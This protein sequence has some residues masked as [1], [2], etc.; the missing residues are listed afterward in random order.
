MLQPIKEILRVR[1]D[2]SK[3]QCMLFCPWNRVPPDTPNLESQSQVCLCAAH[4]WPVNTSYAK[5]GGTKPFTSTPQLA[6]ARS[7]APETRA[8]Q[9]FVKKYTSHV[10]LFLWFTLMQGDYLELTLI[11]VQKLA[12]IRSSFLFWGRNETTITRGESLFRKKKCV[13]L[14]VRVC[15]CMCVGRRGFGTHGSIS[16]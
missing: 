11:I 2:S 6:A 16:D 12:F 9:E 13:C 1:K 14:C 7:T 5:V 15:V 10:R 4:R 8:P 3:T